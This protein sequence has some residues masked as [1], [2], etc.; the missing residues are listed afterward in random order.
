MGT[1][2]KASQILATF[3]KGSVDNSQ[4][5]GL[6]IQRCFL[7]SL[8]ASV[9]CG[10]MLLTAAWYQK[11]E[12][13]TRTGLWCKYRFPIDMRFSVIELGSGEHY[14]V[15]VKNFGLMRGLSTST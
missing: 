12:Q 2:L 8:E 10:F 13:A 4:F 7:G 5:T 6:M 9:N 11:Y 15:L 1:Y 3:K 14:I